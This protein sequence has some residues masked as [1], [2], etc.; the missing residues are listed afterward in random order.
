MGMEP[1]GMARTRRPTGTRRAGERV[2]NDEAVGMKDGEGDGERPRDAIPNADQPG[3]LN[4]GAGKGKPTRSEAV[5]I[6]AGWLRLLVV[7]GGVT[8]VRGV[9]V[10][11]SYGR[12]CV[13]SGYFDYDHLDKAADEALRLSV[14][15]KGMYFCPNPITTDLLGRRA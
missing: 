9:D 10:A 7:P 11:Q 14:K 4:T 12:P 13:E 8:E 1:N 5:R 15:T 2:V 3:G 6:V